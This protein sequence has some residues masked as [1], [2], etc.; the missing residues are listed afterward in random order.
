MKL[1]LKVLIVATSIFPLVAQAELG[2]KFKITAEYQNYAIEGGD[3]DDVE[4]AGTF[5]IIGAGVTVYDQSGLYGDVEYATGSDRSEMALS[6][7]KSFGSYA[8]FGG[9]KSVETTEVE[10]PQEGDQAFDI[11]VSGLF[12]GGSKNFSMGSGTLTIS[13]ALGL[14]MDFTLEGDL[15]NNGIVNN[16]SGS[17]GSTWSLSSAYNIRLENKQVVS[18]GLKYAEYDLG[19]IDEDETVEDLS[20]FDEQITSLYVKYAF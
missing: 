2:H 10:I 14:G 15:N 8:F 16:V 13:A 17:E 19:D 11:E 6:V 5:S 18:L 1:S 4:Q 12:F 20:V 3:N 7:G 9:Y